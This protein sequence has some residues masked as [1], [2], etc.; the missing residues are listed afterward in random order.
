MIVQKEV[1]AKFQD[2][3]A[4]VEN[5]TDALDRQYLVVNFEL[6]CRGSLPTFMLE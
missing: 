3:V 2:E 5:N 4:M 6:H 1:K